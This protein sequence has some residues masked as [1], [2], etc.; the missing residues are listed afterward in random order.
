[1]SENSGPITIAV[2]SDGRNPEIVTMQYLII[3]GGS[4]PGI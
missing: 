4:G 3:T 1:M 2:T